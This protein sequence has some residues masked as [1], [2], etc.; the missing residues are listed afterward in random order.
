LTAFSKKDN[1]G[2]FMKPYIVIPLFALLIL[3]SMFIPRIIQ[4]SYQSSSISLWRSPDLDII[5]YLCNNT[6]YINVTYHGNES[7]YLVYVMIGGYKLD[8]EREIRDDTLINFSVRNK[9]PYM[10]VLRIRYR[11]REFN[12]YV[13]VVRECYK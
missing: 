10:I 5:A 8:I 2:F 3:L 13:Y 7:I 6:L 12:R 9:I 1:G 11:S 4:P